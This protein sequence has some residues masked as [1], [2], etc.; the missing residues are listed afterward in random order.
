MSELSKHF[1]LQEATVSQT[2]ARHGLNNQPDE[3]TLV[4]M[5]LAAEHLELVRDALGAPII[6]SSWYRSPEVDRLVGG[7]GRTNGHSS[8]WCID[9]TAQ[10]Y[11]PREVCEEIINGAFKFD[12]LIYE[13]TWVH[14]SFHPAMRQMVLTAVFVPG[15]PT[16]YRNGLV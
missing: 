10:G 9:F 2:A 3:Q 12:Q 1:S 14:I 4:N 16:T 11:T 8:G 15:Q 6:V 5:K 7:T 13:G